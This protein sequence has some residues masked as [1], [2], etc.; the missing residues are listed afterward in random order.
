MGVSCGSAAGLREQRLTGA[1]GLEIGLPESRRSSA[2]PYAA[3]L[4]AEFGKP[5][6]TGCGRAGF[7]ANVCGRQ[8]LTLAR[9]SEKCKLYLSISGSRSAEAADGFSPDGLICSASWVPG[10]GAGGRS[11]PSQWKLVPSRFNVSVRSTPAWEI[12]AGR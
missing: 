12:P 5:F 10:P 6:K 1:A 8:L 9:P 11:Y 2:A 3:E 4:P 7:Q